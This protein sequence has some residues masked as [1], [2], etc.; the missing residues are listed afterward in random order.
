M[1]HLP[2]L[3]NQISSHTLVILTDAGRRD[4]YASNARGTNFLIVSKLDENSGAM[5]ALSLSRAVGINLR[6]CQQRL[7]ELKRAGY[8]RIANHDNDG[9]GTQQGGV[10]QQ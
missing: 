4:A 1:F 8:V 5:T 7:Q 3:G 9:E 2:F 6:D 10:M